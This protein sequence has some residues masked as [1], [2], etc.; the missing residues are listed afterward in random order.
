MGAVGVMDKQIAYCMLANS[1]TMNCIVMIYFQV[2]IHGSLPARTSTSSA[3]GAKLPRRRATSQTRPPPPRRRR[4]RPPLHLSHV[5]PPPP[6]QTTPPLAPRW[7]GQRRHSAPP[8]P[9]QPPQPSQPEESF[10]GRSAQAAEQNTRF[11]N[12][13]NDLNAAPSEDLAGRIDYVTD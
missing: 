4:P 3:L 7:C 1:L 12:R 6:P 2:S 13:L 10:E 9:P 5:R 8:Q 11:G